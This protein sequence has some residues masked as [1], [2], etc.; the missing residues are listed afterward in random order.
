MSTKQNNLSI[1][2]IGL[3]VSAVLAVIYALVMFASL[4]LVRLGTT[5]SWQAALLDIGWSTAIGFEIGLLGSLIAGFAIALTFVPAYNFIRRRTASQSDLPSTRSWS[6]RLLTALFVLL[7]L[8]LLV[9]RVLA[10]AT[11]FAVTTGVDAA[12]PQAPSVQTRAVNMGPVIN[13]VHRE[14]EPSFTADGRTMYFNCNSGDICVSHLSGTWEQ[15]SWSLP[16]RLEAPINTEYEEVEPVINAT[17]DKLYFTSRRPGGSLWRIPFLS[18]FL[19][20]FR[21][22]NT[23]ATARLGRSFFGG[24]GFSDVFVSYWTDDAWS[25][26]RNL[27][28]IAG[29]PPVNTEFMDHCLFFSADGEEVF[30]TSTRPGGFGGN[31]IWTSRLVNGKWTAPENLGPNVNS[32]G[33]EHHSITTPDGRLIYTTTTREDG[34]G[35]EDIYITTRDANGKWGPLVNLGPLVNGPGDDRC[36]AWTPDHRIFLFDSVNQ[37]GFGSRDIWWLYFENVARNPHTTAYTG[38]PH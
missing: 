24:L 5:G 34:Y 14:V 12:N 18:P 13:T 1:K 19:D 26:P 22:A 7:P 8:S 16:E 9:L 31:D 38:A 36:P 25:E 11:S 2:T 32:P 10:S 4:L 17:G 27:N 6:S 30:W 37:S 23:L 33:D 28:D 20:V 29:E 15:G 3:S 21:V 35:H